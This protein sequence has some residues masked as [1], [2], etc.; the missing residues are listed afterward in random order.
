V[1]KVHAPT[2]DE[3]RKYHQ[4]NSESW[5]KILRMLE[6]TLINARDKR[7]AP[8]YLTKSRV[9]Q[10]ESAY[11]KFKRKNRKDPSL[12]T[13]WIGFRVLCLF[14]QDI[15][16]TFKLLI[17]LML[18]RYEPISPEGVFF[19]LKEIN[20][21][22]WPAEKADKLVALLRCELDQSGISKTIQERE[23]G[24]EVAATVQDGEHKPQTI[25]FSLK[26]ENRGS[27]YQSVHFVVEAKL[28]TSEAVSCEV[29]LRTLLQDVWGEL[30]HALSYKKGK[31]HPHIRNSFQLLS[32][33]LE[34]KDILVSQ[35][36]DIR[37]EESAF[38]HYAHMS[39]GPSK[40]F[41][42]PVGFFEQ[43]LEEPG[44]TK[45]KDYEDWCI[46]RKK[47]SNPFEW[48]TN[49]VEKLSTLAQEL[50]SPDEENCM[51]FLDM[52]N[53]FLK[54][55]SG[56]MRE[57]EEA[58]RK[59]I[60]SK[61][62]S[63][64]WFPFFRLGEVCLAQDKIEEAL[65]A[66]DQCEDQ[67]KASKSASPI[68]DRYAAKIGLAY[69]YWSLGKEFML[70]A[71]HK[72]EEAKTLV[73][74]CIKDPQSTLTI[75][76]KNNL[77]HSLANNLC[78]Y[79]LEHWIDTPASLPVQEIHTRKQRA[80]EQYEIL[81]ALLKRCPDLATSNDYDTLAWYSYQCSLKATNEMD[82][83]KYLDKAKHYISTGDHLAN[84]AP[85]RLT[86]MSTQREH[87]QAIMSKSKP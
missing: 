64:Q 20:I 4:E 68:V 54:F 8:I 40:W 37:D 47:S 78:Y 80:A 26:H 50:K 36:R 69:A 51:Y 45:L 18:N 41:S 27:G 44:K 70:T 60:S 84:A 29:Q 7:L 9:K 67:M 14:Q 73:E 85:S 39:S 61:F 6:S 53:A 32:K 81:E 46:K 24:L 34:A 19:K 1:T 57:A 86:S 43:I 28:A 55:C 12:I 72:M 76:E 13:D 21:F 35:L 25:A 31:I 2:L 83:E 16:P 42:Y 5:Q 17:Q 10:P 52:E 59:I 75:G 11:L 56:E 82:G 22:N 15:E 49:A 62:G 38:A 74:E 63:E 79:Y 65:V 58:Y 71:I 66:F 48:K 77:E 87:I 33:E 30:E 3:V 23:D